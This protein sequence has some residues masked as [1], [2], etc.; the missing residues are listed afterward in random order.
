MELR[1]N[2]EWSSKI[3]LLTMVVSEAIFKTW[4]SQIVGSN[5]SS[6]DGTSWKEASRKETDVETFSL[7]SKVS[8][9]SAEEFDFGELIGKSWFYSLGAKEMMIDAGANE[10]GPLIPH[11]EEVGSLLKGR[12]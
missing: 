5:A 4:A 6:W 3:M 10:V 1:S 7:T 2:L 12:W 11:Y 8:F 9:P